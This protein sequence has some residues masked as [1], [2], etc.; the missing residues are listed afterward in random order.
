MAPIGAP[1]LVAPR[2]RTAI[3]RLNLPMSRILI[4]RS[5]PPGAL[6]TVWISSLLTIVASFCACENALD[7]ASTSTRAA[8]PSIMRCITASSFPVF[9]VLLQRR[10]P[11]NLRWIDL[12]QHRQ[13]RLAEP[14][15]AQ[16]LRGLGE[17]IRLEVGVDLAGVGRH[18]RVVDADSTNGFDVLFHHLRPGVLVAEL[19]REFRIDLRTQRDRLLD[20][21]RRHVDDVE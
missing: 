13:L 8:N 15:R 7:G 9:A 10:Q 2:R 17:R 11:K 20:L 16:N 4:S 14:V 6:T 1:G 21:L 5:P 3:P 18:E 12:E 19:R